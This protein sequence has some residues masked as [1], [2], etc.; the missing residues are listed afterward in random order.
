[1]ACLDNFI[2]VFG[3]CAGNTPTS[4]LYINKA[5]PGITLKRSANLA[6]GEIQTGVDLLN[7]AITNGIEFARAALVSEMMGIVRFNAIHSTGQYGQFYKDYTD[8]DYYLAA[9]AANRGLKFELSQCCKLTSLYI[10]RVQVL[11]NSTLSS[12]TLTITDGGTTTTKT[13]ST[14]AQVPTDVEVNYKASSPTVL[15]TLDNTS[16]SVNNS[17]L[18]YSGSCGF[19][20]ND[21]CN[22]HLCDKA[23]SVWGWDGTNTNGTSYGLSARVDVVCDEYKFFCELAN[24]IPDVAWLTMYHAGIWFFEYLLTTGRVNVY[25]LYN[26]E[27]ISARIEQWSQKADEIEKKI[28]KQ[29]PRYLAMID[30]CCVECNSSRW[31][32]SIP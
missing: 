30:D 32:T 24:A 15:I 29:L 2:L 26:K 8:T 22:N 6:E 5:L 17:T 7:Q 13:F 28:V 27:T 31:E 23:L 11:M 14:T 3:H 20:S 19:C 10:R 25:T 4:G 9:S 18:N 1:M 12:Q 21:C 16:Q